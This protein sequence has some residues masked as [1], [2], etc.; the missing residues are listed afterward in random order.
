[1]KKAGGVWDA[2]RKV[3]ELAYEQVERLGLE[4]RIVG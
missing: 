2:E 3:W 1:V 4:G